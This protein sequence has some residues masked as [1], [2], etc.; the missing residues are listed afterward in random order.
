MI[1]T[2]NAEPRGN[3]KKPVWVWCGA[4]PNVKSIKEYRNQLYIVDKKGRIEMLVGASLDQQG[5]LKGSWK[6]VGQPTEG[7]RSICE[8]NDKLMG[9]GTDNHLYQWSDERQ[10]WFSKT[11]KFKLLSILFCFK[12]V[13]SVISWLTK[14]VLM[15]SLLLL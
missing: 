2:K 15:L 4:K 6:R 14:V 3:G 11:T 7:L 10:N 13:S 12:F 9:V 5:K 1:N 8:W